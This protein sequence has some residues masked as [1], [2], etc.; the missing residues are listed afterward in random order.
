VKTVSRNAHLATLLADARAH[1]DD[2]CGRVWLHRL[3]GFRA[4]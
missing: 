4:A 3:M 1:S 2:G